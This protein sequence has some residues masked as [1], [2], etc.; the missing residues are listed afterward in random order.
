MRRFLPLILLAAIAAAYFGYRRYLSSRPF[1]WAGTIEA[2]TVTV[3]S[4]TG[5]RVKQVL[6]KEG[7]LV[8]AGQPLLVLEP[9]DLEA[10]RAIAQAQLEQARAM[11]DKLQKGARPEEI[12]QAK[13]RADQAAAA[14]AETRHG[15]RV[16]EIAAAEARVAQAQAAVD[17]AQ[18]ESDRAHKLLA[19]GAIPKAQADAADTQLKTA[20][21]Q[22][23]AL[24][25]VYEQVRSG[26][27]VEEKA[28]AAA[29]ADEAQA[30][31]KLVLAGPRVEDLRAAQA[32][33]DGAKARVDQLDVMV[34]ELTV[35]SPAVA[36]V[37]AL[38]LR[39]G[40]I[41]A[42]NAPAA[43][44]LED[45]QLFVRMYVPETQIGRVHIGDVVPIQVD[46]FDRTFK[47]KVEHIN[48]QGEYSPRNLQTADERAD[49][50]FAVR[51]GLIEGKDQ[52]RAGMAA[53]IRV[54]K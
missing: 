27:R 47:G 16:E 19:S 52:L 37:E 2:R 54:S 32:T 4:R 30:A 51:I 28:Q 41:L 35:R 39:A 36:R 22:R 45:G 26:A 11:L 50:V 8:Q 38:E 7:D 9:G 33:V 40:D 6:A 13:A 20:I 1:E 23:D 25:K 5:G 14:L 29:R 31:A 12:A 15:S 53:T 43:T 3:G 44:L 34:G 49:Q 21:A 42:P 46:S 48:E 18:L 10:Q 17:Q 24:Q